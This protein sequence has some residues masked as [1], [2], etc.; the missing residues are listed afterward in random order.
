M[1]RPA[2]RAL[3]RG[4]SP[5]SPTRTCRSASLPSPSVNGTNPPSKGGTRFDSRLGVPFGVREGIK[6]QSREIVVS[7]CRATTGRIAIRPI[8]NRARAGNPGY[9]EPKPAGVCQGVV[10][11]WGSSASAKAFA[12]TASARPPRQETQMHRSPVEQLRCGGMV[13][14]NELASNRRKAIRN[15]NG[16]E[17]WVTPC[18]QMCQTV[19][20]SLSVRGYHGGQRA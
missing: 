9:R 20:F 7:P 15:P 13:E 6:L 5:R 18:R 10:P 4:L 12:A 14:E 3:D 19:S 1:V 16:E 11:S 17:R 8:E 2:G